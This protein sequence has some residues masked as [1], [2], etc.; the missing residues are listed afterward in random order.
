[1]ASEN[2]AADLTRRILGCAF[3]VHSELGPGLLESAYR[4]CLI[5]EL[6]VAGLAS[7]EEIPVPLHYR[8]ENIDC[9]YRADL[10]VE[11]TVLIELK[12]VK[13]LKAIHTAQAL[14]YM[15]IARLPLGLILNFNTVS[16]RDGVRRLVL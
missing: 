5:R 13:R 8:G 15:R 10:V 6:T 11:G 12:C 16:L 14:T 9:A 4:K 3:R 2:L 7:R 1:M